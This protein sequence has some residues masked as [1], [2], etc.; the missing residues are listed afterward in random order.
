MTFNVWIQVDSECT[1][2]YDDVHD[3]WDTGCDN[4][5]RL[6]DGTPTGN[7]FRFCAYCGKPII[8]VTPKRHEQ[9]ESDNPFLDLLGGRPLAKFFLLLSYRDPLILTDVSD[10]LNVIVRFKNKKHAE[11]FSDCFIEVMR[12]LH[13]RPDLTPTEE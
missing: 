7:G 11:E 1:W 2:T 12:G 13:N 10:E 9:M 3:K 6:I 5:F 4:E 8:E